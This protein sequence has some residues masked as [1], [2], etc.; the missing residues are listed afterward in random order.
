VLLVSLTPCFSGV[1][2]K[3]L[4]EL[5]RFSGFPCAKGMK[6]AE[7]V[8]DFKTTRHTPLKRGINETD[9]DDA[10]IIC[11][12]TRLANYCHNR[13]FHAKL[14]I[15]M[16]TRFETATVK[17]APAIALLRNSA[18]DNLTAKFGKGHWSGMVTERGVLYEMKKGTAYV[19][20]QNGK[21][22]A[23]LILST[24]KPW[25]IDRKFFKNSDRPLYLTSMAVTPEIQRQGIGRRC[26]T[27][28]LEAARKWPGDAIRL[29][30][31][32]AEGGAGEFYRKCGFCEV[33]R[34]SYRDVPLIYFEC[35]L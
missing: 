18:S 27:G 4:D 31:Y 15:E 24:R 33:G 14:R 23:T 5:N 20:R 6:T 25:A 34:A 1:Q 7:A 30:A 29:D 11:A 16:S 21:V 22:I 19:M 8:D 10:Y 17:D 28:A 35:L 12:P 13:P 9:G 2:E 26:I 3:S 32:D